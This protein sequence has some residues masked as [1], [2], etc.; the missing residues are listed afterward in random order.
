M[1]AITTKAKGNS[2]GRYVYTHPFYSP[3]EQFA[4]TETESIQGSTLEPRLI[5]T[6]GLLA[7][8]AY[9]EKGQKYQFAPQGV[10]G[11]VEYLDGTA[12]GN[13]PLPGAADYFTSEQYYGHSDGV[14][15]PSDAQAAAMRV[16]VEDPR[17]L[18][19]RFEDV[20]GGAFAEQQMGMRY[21]LEEPERFL[22][23]ENLATTTNT[24]EVAHAVQSQNPFV[25]E[26]V[27]M[28]NTARLDTDREFALDRLEQALQAPNLPG[29]AQMRQ[30][31]MEGLY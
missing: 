6:A 16:H 4:Y 19:P 8:G 22:L 24:M 23:N 27:P 29:A 15:Q 17:R 25:R 5:R 9:A 21:E 30:T 3:Y 18:N 11:A 20:P 13:R 26:S 14:A 28:P 2:N 10:K 1:R 7:G 31:I 12:I